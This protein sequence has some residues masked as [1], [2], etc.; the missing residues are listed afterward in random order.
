MRVAVVTSP[1]TGSTFCLRLIS[2]L[3]NLKNYE[4]ILNELLYV[5]SDD[6]YVRLNTDISDESIF[7]KL[8]N[9]DDYVVKIIA[10]E[11][12]ERN[13]DVNNFPWN[14]FDK[15][16][17]LERDNIFEQI[18]SW[19]NLSYWQTTIIKQNIHK[20]YYVK[21]GFIEFA[22]D[23]IKKY[24]F[25]K[26]VVNKNTSNC[27]VVKKE[28]IVR[29]ISIIFDKHITE[30]VMVNARKLLVPECDINNVDYS[31]VMKTQNVKQRVLTVL[32]KELK[33]NE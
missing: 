26:D 5:F 18:I 12:F 24:H 16:I 17:L 2:N 4:E 22:V 29:D 6:S 14:I 30:D 11:L 1:R 28:N 32:E 21:D 8:L 20:T 7:N 3:L 15:I 23:C 9:T 27:V 10:S 19:Y 25:V 33:W 13:F 31:I